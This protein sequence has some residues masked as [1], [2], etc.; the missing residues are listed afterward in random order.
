MTRLRCA[1]ALMGIASIGSVARGQVLYGSLTGN[2][3]DQTG[4]AVPRTN[5]KGENIATGIS[6][7]EVTDVHGVYLFRNLQPGTYRV[8]AQAPGFQA[9]IAN[10]VPVNAHEVRRIDFNLTIA[11]AAPS[12]EVTA[13]AAVLQMDTADVH[14]EITSREITELPYNG[15]EARISKACCTWC[16]APA[17][18]PAAR[19]TP[20]RATRCARRR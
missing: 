2:V 12:L 16:P 4:A 6:R 18:R 19:P 3:L 15:G 11:Q 8:T 1:I 9:T 20:K 13:A 7:Q 10:G 5:V 17:F 14:Q